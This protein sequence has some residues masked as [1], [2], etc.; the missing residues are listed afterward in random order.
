MNEIVE[1]SKACV[2]H[3]SRVRTHVQ[4]TYFIYLYSYSYAFD[5]L[6]YSTEMDDSNLET[7]TKKQIK[8]PYIR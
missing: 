8:M 6:F 2:Y 7:K 3:R 1:Y 5:V 4:Q